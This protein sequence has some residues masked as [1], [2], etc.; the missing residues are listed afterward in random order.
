MQLQCELVQTILSIDIY[1]YTHIFSELHA[2]TLQIFDKKLGG[3]A[4]AIGA[5]ALYNTPHRSFYCACAVFTV[6]T[7]N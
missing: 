2:G 4:W 6:T 7:N 5:L 3:S 1:V